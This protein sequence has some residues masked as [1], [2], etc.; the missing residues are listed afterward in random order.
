MLLLSHK[1][2]FRQKFKSSVVVVG[3]VTTVEL[4]VV[5]GQKV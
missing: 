1:L 2:F 5:I 3:V 4:G